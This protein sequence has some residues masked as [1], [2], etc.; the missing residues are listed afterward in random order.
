MFTGISFFKVLSSRSIQHASIT[1]S[2]AHYSAGKKI[3]TTPDIDHRSI[4]WSA[5]YSETEQTKTLSRINQIA[6]SIIKQIECA[7]KDP[8]SSQHHKI[9]WAELFFFKPIFDAYGIRYNY[10]FAQQ[11]SSSG[12]LYIYSSTNKLTPTKRLYTAYETAYKY[13]QWL[14]NLDMRI[15]E[16]YMQQDQEPK[17]LDIESNESRTVYGLFM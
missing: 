3:D 13:H 7:S 2:V 6:D 11:V 17:S 14:D 8:F 16:A 1:G 4:V 12:D 9:S 5:F 10:T 15:Q